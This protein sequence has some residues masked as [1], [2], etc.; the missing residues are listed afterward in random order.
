M[1]AMIKHDKLAVRNSS[2]YLGHTSL[3]FIVNGKM[4][5]YNIIIICIQILL[6]IIFKLTGISIVQKDLHFSLP[7]QGTGKGVHKKLLEDIQPAQDHEDIQFLR[8]LIGIT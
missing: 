2:Q 1:I 8:Y 6:K 4:W 3:Q 7:R 5:G